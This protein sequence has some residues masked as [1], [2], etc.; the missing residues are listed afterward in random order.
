MKN[1]KD[2]L[3]LLPL[4]LLMACGDNTS[5]TYSDDSDPGP[6]DGTDDEMTFFE[7]KMCDSSFKMNLV[8]TGMMLRFL[9]CSF[10]EVKKPISLYASTLDYPIAINCLPGSDSSFDGIEELKTEIEEFR[11]NPH[12]DFLAV[13][14]CESPDTL[15]RQRQIYLDTSFPKAIEILSYAQSFHIERVGETAIKYYE[16]ISTCLLNSEV[17]CSDKFSYAELVEQSSNFKNLLWT[18]EENTSEK[19][20]QEFYKKYKSLKNKVPTRE[21][22]KKLYNSQLQKTINNLLLERDELELKA[23]RLGVALSLYRSVDFTRNNIYL[24]TDVK[25]LEVSILEYNSVFD[26]ESL[27]KDLLDLKVLEIEVSVKNI[28]TQ[29]DQQVKKNP[30]FYI[31]ATNSYKFYDF[32]FN[33]LDFEQ[34]ISNQ[35]KKDG[36]GNSAERHGYHYLNTVERLVNLNIPLEFSTP[37]VSLYFNTVRQNVCAVVFKSL[38]KKESPSILKI[39]KLVCHHSKFSFDKDSG[40]LRVNVNSN[41]E[42]L[43]N[44]LENFNK[45]N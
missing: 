26:N 29:L 27:V 22:F 15:L 30:M 39:K 38:V 3:F 12:E 41:R 32:P 36:K 28:Y 10:S 8:E 35:F 9:G 5:S 45:S 37:K 24:N 34:Y 33:N 25:F 11:K 44:F 13:E 21:D 18:L 19:F 6:T 7:K 31:E 4:V 1:I 43:E 16:N 23:N 42:D 40:I 20:K 17:E 2:L 14:D